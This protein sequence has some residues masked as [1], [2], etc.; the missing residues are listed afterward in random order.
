MVHSIINQRLHYPDTTAINQEDKNKE[1]TAYDTTIHGLSV[2]VCLGKVQSTYKSY[3]LLFAP[4]YLVKPNGKVLQIGVYEFTLAKYKY[5]KDE[6]GELDFYKLS[7]TAKPLLH[8]FATVDYV[9]AI[10]YGLE[11]HKLDID[12]RLLETRRAQERTTEEYERI[13]KQEIVEKQTQSLATEL[14]NQYDLSILT[15]SQQIY[16]K[17]RSRKNKLF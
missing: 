8:T 9:S 3:G 14:R 6:S 11:K 13:I 2:T 15:P 5:F 7:R 4:I 17:N 10:V 1:L 16:S 12:V